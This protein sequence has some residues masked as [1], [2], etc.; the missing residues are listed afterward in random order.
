MKV[1]SR[2]RISPI[3]WKFNMKISFVVVVVV[4]EKLLQ[5][6]FEIWYELIALVGIKIW[7]IFLICLLLYTYIYYDSF[8]GSKKVSWGNKCFFR[9][10]KQNNNRI[11]TVLFFSKNTQSCL[12]I[13]SHIYLL[14][15]EVNWALWNL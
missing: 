6:T 14:W 10:S 15:V 5:I 12:K 9:N 13:L 11:K 8:L 7:K 2:L 3:R 1:C 4:A